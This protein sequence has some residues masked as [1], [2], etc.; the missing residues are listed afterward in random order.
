M[1]F[2][3]FQK[4]KSVRNNT[5]EKK[6]INK[7]IF[8]FPATIL[9]ISLIFYQKIDFFELILQKTAFLK[10]RFAKENITFEA[11]QALELMANEN[12][13]L[14]E[15]PFSQKI[16]HDLDDTK[17]QKCTNMLLNKKINMEWAVKNQSF[18]VA[19]FKNKVNK[20]LQTS[21]RI[22]LNKSSTLQQQ[23]LYRFG[24]K[25]NFFLEINKSGLIKNFILLES[26]GMPEVD[27]FIKELIYSVE[28]FPQIPNHLNLESL[29]LGCDKNIF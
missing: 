18:K 15:K 26:S 16:K 20:H 22:T 19:A 11:Q 14:I 29:V 3:I 13:P 17:V 12:S 21:V 8:F 5:G 23:M 10:K 28:P 6:R 9:L 24:R 2:I 25:I 7:I 4:E 1:F 27:L